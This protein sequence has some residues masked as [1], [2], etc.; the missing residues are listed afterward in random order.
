MEEEPVKYI[1]KLT[2]EGI[3][4]S[5]IMTALSH[6]I[7]GFPSGIGSDGKRISFSEMDERLNEYLKKF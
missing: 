6:H 7:D 1:P 3:L 2:T 4:I 5:K